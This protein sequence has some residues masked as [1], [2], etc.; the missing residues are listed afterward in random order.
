MQGIKALP[1][2]A[3]AEVDEKIR[4]EEAGSERCH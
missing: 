1:R 2:T 4:E 3:E